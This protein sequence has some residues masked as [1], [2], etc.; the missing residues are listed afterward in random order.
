METRRFAM[1]QGAALLRA[2]RTE[3][4][5]ARRGARPSVNAV[6]D[7]RVATRRL[8]ACL[9][10]FASEF[11]RKGAR[12]LR[13]QIREL[14]KAAGAVRDR[15]IAIELYREAGEPAPPRLSEER[16][17]RGAALRSIT[18]D[19]AST[20][21][22][23]RHP[24]ELPA[25]DFGME[26]LSAMIPKF[27]RAGRKALDCGPGSRQLHAFR[28]EGKRLR[29]TLELFAPLLNR[30]IV[31][32]ILGVLR[33]VQHLL[34]EISDCQSVRTLLVKDASPSM[35]EFLNKREHH[36]LAQFRRYWRGTVERREESWQQY[37]LKSSEA[38]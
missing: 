3:I 36:R 25:R 6:H 21:E 14:R 34:G 37:F 5:H 13:L 30:R 32:R 1:E 8:D 12:K 31:Q 24:S 17:V 35:T 2:V 18:I 19:A 7:V 11:R 4:R 15:D 10:V 20:V 9:D 29:Y 33:R 22:L 28:I 16:V 26:L 38:A 23:R 27:F